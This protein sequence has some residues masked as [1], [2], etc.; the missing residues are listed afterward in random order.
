VR[1]AVR[2]QTRVLR[3]RTDD[4]VASLRAE[5]PAPAVPHGSPALLLMMG[6][7]GTGKSHCARLLAVRLDAAHV[8]SDAL[9][10]RLFVA[11]SYADEENAA[12]FRIVDALVERLLDE[13]HR[14]VVDATHLRHMTRASMARIARRRGIP[15]AYLLVT[16][17]ERDILARLAAR[18][19]APSAE[20]RSDADE[21]V[22]LA[23]RARGFEEPDEPYLT[24]RSGPSIER[25][26]DELARALGERWSAAT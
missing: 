7:P 23:M 5:I 18:T 11:A 26:V 17:E 2:E 21:R 20:D 13:G 4:A 9:R 8:A 14:V 19:S 6:L 10:S 16:A 25:D 12:V 1:K 15:I 24:V 3:D 22:Y